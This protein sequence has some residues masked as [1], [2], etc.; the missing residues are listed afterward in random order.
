MVSCNSGVYL[1]E[2][3]CESKVINGEIPLQHSRTL[4]KTNFVNL[5]DININKF[6]CQICPYLAEH[7]S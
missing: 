1:Q 5:I 2:G 4:K 7:R 3:K 6:K